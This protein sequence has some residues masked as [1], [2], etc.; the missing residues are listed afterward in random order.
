MQTLH[1]ACQER[2]LD[3]SPLWSRL[4]FALA[5]IISPP[6]LPLLLVL[7]S[8]SVLLILHILP[9]PLFP[10]SLFGLPPPLRHADPSV[11]SS[12]SLASLTFFFHHVFYSFS[13]KQHP[14]HYCSSSSFATLVSFLTNFSFWPLYCFLSS[15]HILHLFFCLISVV[16]CFLF[17]V[18]SFILSYYLHRAA[19]PL[20]AFSVSFSDC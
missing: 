16:N 10:P 13:G 8:T 11:L 18:S 12:S 3:S 6:V 9:S 4:R 5:V 19:C 2:F 14:L 1:A 20:S 7:L 17:I 15:L